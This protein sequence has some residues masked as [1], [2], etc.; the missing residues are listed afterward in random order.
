M[1]PKAVTDAAG[2][3]RM[4]ALTYS[5]WFVDAKEFFAHAIPMP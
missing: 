4:N 2:V 5:L 3:T 1:R